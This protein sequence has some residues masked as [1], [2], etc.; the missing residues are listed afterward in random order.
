M[1]ATTVRSP[2][3]ACCCSLAVLVL[4]GGGRA[5][6]DAKPLNGEE[7]ARVNKAIDQG[8]QYLRRSQGGTGTWAPPKSGHPVGYAALPGL[9]LLECGVPATD[10]AVRRTAAFV[11]RS[12]GNLDATYDLALCILFLDRLGDPKDQALIQTLALR[13]VA[14]QTPT[15][16]WSYKCLLV[17]KK[18]QEEL[19]TALRQLDPLAGVPADKGPADRPLTVP[20]VPAKKPPDRS[21]AGKAADAPRPADKGPAPKGPAEAAP[22]PARLKALPVFRDPDRLAKRDAITGTPRLSR[23]DNSNTQFALLALWVAQRHDV[24]LER[25]LRLIARRFETS[26]NDD[27]SWG[28]LYG[29]A[30][31]RPAMTCVGLL[32][33]A[34][35]HGL[36]RGPGDAAPGAGKPVQDPRIVNG[37]VALSRDVGK[38]AGSWRDL[39][40]ENLYFLWSV[41]RVGVLY[42]LPTIGDSD[43]Y[44]W[45]AEI[46]VA[47]QEKR[48]AWT[49]GGYHGSD[50]AIDTCLA[51]LFL[52][53]ANFVADLT[54]KLPFKPA[55]LSQSIIIR[56][57]ESSGTEKKPR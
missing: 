8:V 29:D 57:T 45:G 36:A 42:G 38:P 14:G 18:T 33:L 4:A 12:T 56:K 51:L 39:P 30:Q 1:D 3:L 31:G 53:R 16:G 21:P 40:M 48:G 19:M 52:K 23:S 32:G 54:S 15:G 46:L 10:P 55:E 11:R 35:G 47:N 13:L 22:L 27:G 43:W 41:E 49:R 34:V 37:L 25:T 20:P 50:P 9:T 6:A 17:G 5:R 2:W 24:P 44:R 7:Q 26:Q 28:Y